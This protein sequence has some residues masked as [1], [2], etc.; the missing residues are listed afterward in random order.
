M[1]RNPDRA[2]WEPSAEFWISMVIA[3]TAVAVVVKVF[4]L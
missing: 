1:R 3:F 4:W 2:T